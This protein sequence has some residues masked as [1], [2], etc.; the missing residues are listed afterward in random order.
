MASILRHC[1]VVL[2]RTQFPGNIGAT[3]RAMRNFGL[4]ELTL[5]APECDPLDTNARQMS[6][7]GEAILHQ[8]RITSSLKEAIADCVIVVGTSARVGGLFRKQPVA[9]PEEILPDVAR[10]LASGQKA[11]LVF[12]PERNGLTN[13]ETTLC[14][15]LIQIPT[16][17]EYT[18]LNLAL[19]VGICLYLLHRS[20]IKT[21]TVDEPTESLA[22]WQEQ[23]HMFRQLQPAL[24]R[25]RFLFGD[26]ATALMHAMRH[27][28]G[29]AR[30]TRMEVKLLHGLARQIQWF[31]DQHE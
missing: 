20:S 10:M 11:A 3:A 31:A 28:L 23:D 24:E 4:T 30:L 9:S 22:T 26:R 13:E 7:Q 15:R 29:K 6:T 27:L 16:A 1:R 5:V 14:H 12:G 8:A 19:S 21:P 2:V 18:S 25:I 17:E